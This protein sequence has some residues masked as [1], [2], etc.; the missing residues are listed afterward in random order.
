MK[1]KTTTNQERVK[2][3]LK[4]L[5]DCTSDYIAARILFLAELPPQAAIFSSTAIE[6]AFKTILAFNGNESRGH[7][8]K[9]HWNAAKNFDKTFYNSINED[10]LELNKKAYKLRYTEDLPLGYN[11]AILSREFLAELDHTIMSLIVRFQFHA[12][13]RKIITALDHVLKSK[14]PRIWN[15]NHVLNKESKEAFIYKKPQFVFEIRN[16]KNVILST[17]Y[18]TKGKPKEKNFL[19]SAFTPLDQ[20]EKEFAFACSDIM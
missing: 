18:F 7:L 13:D 19:R 1:K 12:E 15:E 17:T 6:K 11:V 4:F 2:L 8:Q 20:N 16:H 3:A 9:A 5:S 14:D 10:F